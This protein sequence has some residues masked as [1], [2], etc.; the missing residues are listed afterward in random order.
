MPLPVLGLWK[1]HEG[2]G[3]IEKRTWILVGDFKAQL[4]RWDYLFAPLEFKVLPSLECRASLISRV[5][6][7][8]KAEIHPQLMYITLFLESL[9]IHTCANIS[10]FKMVRIRDKVTQ[11][12][13]TLHYPQ[14]RTGNKTFCDLWL[15]QWLFIAMQTFYLQNSTLS[16]G[17]NL[18]R[19]AGPADPSYT[20]Q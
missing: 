19:E 5:F 6:V 9:L 3:E 18:C 11:V 7:L 8:L 14:C 12:R 4:C 10:P 13:M 1:I 17:E 20:M 2:P 16:W 15:S